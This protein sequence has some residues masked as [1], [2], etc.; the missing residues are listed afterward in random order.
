MAAK[1]T[2]PGVLIL[3]DNSDA[4]LA[5]IPKELLEGVRVVNSSTLNQLELVTKLKQ[6]TPHG[7]GLDVA[8]DCVGNE[9]VV[10]TA[11]EALGKMAMLLNIGGNPT[12]KPH[13]NIERNLV[14]GLTIRGTHQGDSVS[15]EMIP[16]LI[17]MWRDGQFPFDKL[18]TKFRFEELDRAIE[19]VH[20][21]NV[22]KPLLVT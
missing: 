9:T 16:R 12:A 2:K 21:G 17:Q 11:Y 8:L 14:N 10:N 1:T 7:R 19:E 13:F 15:R 5:M 18:L 22:I 6:L 4:K 3:I 20:K